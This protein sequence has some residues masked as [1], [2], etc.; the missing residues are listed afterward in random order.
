MFDFILIATM[1]SVLLSVAVSTG[2]AKSYMPDSETDSNPHTTPYDEFVDYLCKYSDE[3]SI[4]R[5]DFIR[6]FEK[7]MKDWNGEYKPVAE[8]F[9]K[10]GENGDM[11]RIF[12]VYGL[13]HHLFE[14][15][16]MRRE[17]YPTGEITKLI[18]T[19]ARNH[20]RLHKTDKR[21]FKAITHY[22]NA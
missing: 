9:C 3:K 5:E 8:A 16:R 15:K 21:F 11:S 18:M 7:E 14:I 17:N 19:E 6:N 1:F 12:N 22:K 10:M 2:V 4:L 13:R 20:H